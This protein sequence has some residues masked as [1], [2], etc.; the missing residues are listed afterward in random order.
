MNQKTYIKTVG[1]QLNCSTSRKKEIQRQLESDIHAALEQ[2]ETMEE[3]C[4]RMG[5]P[6]ELAEEFNEN[7][8]EEE[9]KLAKRNKVRK[10]IT[11]ILIIF[12]AL[13]LGGFWLLPKST[14]IE[15]S[16]VFE[17][18][19]LEIQTMEIISLL[20]KRIMLH[21]RPEQTRQ[22]ELT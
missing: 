22:S 9:H 11:V 20:E 16:T 2:G 14:P 6:I 13:G 21:Y 8:S 19:Q 1:R 12:L 18:E 15:K 10:T 17:E 3:I 7:L 4:Q 5:S